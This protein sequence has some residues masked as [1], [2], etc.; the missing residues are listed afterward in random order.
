MTC[1]KYG[2]PL[3]F[4]GRFARFARCAKPPFHAWVG[5][6][7]PRLGELAANFLAYREGEKVRQNGA[8]PTA[9]RRD[10]PLLAQP[11]NRANRPR[12]A[13]GDASL[14]R[15]RGPPQPAVSLVLRG[16]VPGPNAMNQK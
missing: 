13:Y 1:R 4:P 2:I 3:V 7:R 11:A 5:P 6:I 16:T 12:K 9:R 10:W 14:P 15:S 8:L